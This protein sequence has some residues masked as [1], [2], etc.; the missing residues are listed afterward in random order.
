MKEGSLVIINAH[1]PAS[2]FSH[3]KGLEEVILSKGTSGLVISCETRGPVPGVN[4]LFGGEENVRW[5]PTE[6]LSIVSK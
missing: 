3:L 4:V 5:I 6:F 1:Y 2:V